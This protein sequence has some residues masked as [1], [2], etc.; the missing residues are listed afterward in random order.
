MMPMYIFVFIFRRMSY[1]CFDM[2]QGKVRI[3]HLLF[4]NNIPQNIHQHLFLIAKMAAFVFLFPWFV[5]T[6]AVTFTNAYTGEI[7][8]A[9]TYLGW[10]WGWIMCAPCHRLQCALLF[11]RLFFLILFSRTNERIFNPFGLITILISNLWVII[12]TL[13]N[14]YHIMDWIIMHTTHHNIQHG[15]ALACSE[16]IYRSVDS[17]N[18]TKWGMP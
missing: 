6:F 12:V 13:S 11:S 2:K 18:S 1:L 15:L 9:E 14:V 5:F 4:M 7:L 10:L 8:L 3:Q 17:F 16:W